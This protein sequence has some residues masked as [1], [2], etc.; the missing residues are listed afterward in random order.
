MR[1]RRPLPVACC[2]IALCVSAFPCFPVSAF[3][4]V[5]I[6]HLVRPVDAQLI[7]SELDAK[8]FFEV[9]LGR[10]LIDRPIVLRHD[11]T[12]SGK[13]LRSVLVYTGPGEWA[14]ILGDA[15]KT[16]Y[17]SGV[18]SLSITGGGLRGQ[19]Y[20]QHCWIRDV[21]I[22]GATGDGLRLDGVGDRFTVERVYSWQNGGAG[23]RIVA[24]YGTSNGLMLEKCNAQGNAGEGVVLETTSWGGQLVG[25]TLRDCTIQGNALADVR[26]EILIKG[27]VAFTIIDNC[28]VEGLRKLSLAPVGPASPP[29]IVEAGPPGPASVAPA[30]PPVSHPVV[31]LRAVPAGPFASPTGVVNT[32]RPSDLLID[33][34][35]TFHGYQRAMELVA[36][37]GQTLLGHA[38]L[39]NN[40]TIVW[41]SASD[42]VSD[43]THTKKPVLQ[44]SASRGIKAEAII[45]DPLLE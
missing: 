40:A 32:R 31:G 38:W 1:P 9:P 3:Q 29:V 18:E 15:T 41:K 26:S 37:N 14:V 12:L 24:A 8:G 22:S 11:Q 34:G 33:G 28:H 45:A 10:H 42:K 20:G 39:V 44:V 19:R 21:W 36:M 7:Q 2:L 6:D 35:T 25:T 27:W 17:R 16:I 5:V 43:S 13:G 30:S 4:G 23:F